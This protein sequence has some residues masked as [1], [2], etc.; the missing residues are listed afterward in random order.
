MIKARYKKYELHFKQPAGT[1]R[2][3]L[4]TRTVWYL[5]LEENG[6]TGLGEC[7][8]L[9]GLSMETPEQVEEQLEIICNDPEPYI[10]NIGLLQDLPSL[11]FA[12]ESALLDLKNGGKRDPFPSAF[13]SGKAGI[14]IN[15]LI[16]MNEIDNMQRQIE[17]KLAAGFRCIKLKIGAKDFEQELELLKAIRE[18]YSSD[19]I[20]LRVDANGAFDTNWAPAKLKRLAELQLHS[21]EQP[22]QAGQW[23]EMAELCKTTP[24]PIALDEELIGVN[25]REE[26]IQL[27]ETI[28]P[29]YLVLK[30]SLHGGISGCDEWIELAKERYIG[31]WIT[32]YLESNIG[33]N[34]IAQWAF[35][36]NTSMHQGLG[37]GQLFTNNVSSPLEIRGEKLWFNT[38]KSFEM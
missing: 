7:A 38:A 35:T 33:L 13:T 14:P 12:L 32:S 25:K 20:I 8:P 31:W 22:I 9:P 27:L 1:S 15:G 6:V 4:K 19:E 3:V 26:K 37:T 21:I 16:W 11:K 23:N 29:Q 30:P 34:A 17:E 10:N 24:L 2:G 36:K 18:R 28:Q 5:F